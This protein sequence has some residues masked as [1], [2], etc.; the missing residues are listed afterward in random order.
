VK[1]QV[2]TILPSSA[3]PLAVSPAAATFGTQSGSDSSAV[4]IQVTE[5]SCSVTA[6]PD[7]SVQVAVQVTGCP[8][9]Q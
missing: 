1:L 2:R 8:G 7:S 3:V 5:A 4:S 9:M 6:V